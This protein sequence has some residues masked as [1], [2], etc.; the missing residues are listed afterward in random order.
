LPAK[1][2]SG[3]WG[4]VVCGF[5]NKASNEMCGGTGPMGCKAPKGM[6]FES[7]M[8]MMMPMM[9]MMMGQ[10]A[11]GGAFPG[12]GGDWGPQRRRPSLASTASGPRWLCAECGFTNNM[13]NSVCGGTGPMGCKA[14]KPDDAEE[15]E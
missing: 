3:D 6:D 12:A 14:V 7:M 15:V 4:C 1:R 8:P 5:M 10:M 2:P 11:A 9:A 13:K